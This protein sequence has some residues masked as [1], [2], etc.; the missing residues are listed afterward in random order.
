M[1]CGERVFALDD[2]RE[3]REILLQLQ[4]VACRTALEPDDRVDVG[5]RRRITEA[6]TINLKQVTTST[7]VDA[8]SGS[9][10]III[11]IDER[12]VALPA[13]ERVVARIFVEI[14]VACTTVDKV[15][16]GFRPEVLVSVAA[17]QGV[18]ASLA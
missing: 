9:V 2:I 10:R 4:D 17:A 3:V 1:A 11:Q 14:V 13:K 12:V 8:V 7:P 6:A 18:V 15:V 16:A 5:S